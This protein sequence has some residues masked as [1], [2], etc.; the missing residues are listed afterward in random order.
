MKVIDQYIDVLLK[1][2]DIYS[3]I[4]GSPPG[5][6]KTTS[7]LNK[8]KEMGLVEDVHFMYISGYITPLMLY[9]WLNQCRMLDSPRLFIADDIDYIISN[10]ISLAILKS[11]LSDDVDNKRT[12]CYQSSNKELEVKSFD[13][14]GKV[15][16]LTNNLSNN[17]HLQP[18]LDRGIV[19]DFNTNPEEMNLYIEANLVSMYPTLDKGERDNVWG[20]VKRFINEPG[21][22]FRS[23]HRAF[24]FYK[25]NRDNW[26]SMFAR[27]MKRIAR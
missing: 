16:I 27:T 10:K 13:F 11:A 12:V 25:Y 19:Y 2:D 5:M 23:L 24:S 15:I 22:S 9:N 3:L 20:K 7:V 26:Y 17:K 8:L 14:N 18:L 1:S 21:F 4:I 6:G